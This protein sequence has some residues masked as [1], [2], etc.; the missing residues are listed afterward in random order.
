[1]AFATPHLPIVH[2]LC[3]GFFASVV[4]AAGEIIRMRLAGWQAPVSLLVD[5]TLPQLVFGGAIA[6]LVAATA[7]RCLTAVF[8]VLPSRRQ[9]GLNHASRA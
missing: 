3:A 7:A 5:M 6:S 1:V 2:A 8:G 4:I 9:P